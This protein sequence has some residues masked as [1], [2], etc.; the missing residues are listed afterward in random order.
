M[1]TQNLPHLPPYQTE[2]VRG[3]TREVRDL[4]RDVADLLEP[5][6][7]SF[8]PTADRATAC[9]ILVNHLSMRR[10]K[11]C[12]LA[13]HRT[14][15]DKLEELVWNGSDVADLSGQ[16]VRDG[17]GPNGAGGGSGGM[18]VSA[19]RRR[20]TCGSTAT[21][22]PRTRA[23]GQTSTSRAAWSRRGTYSSTSGS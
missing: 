3:V 22:W 17:S 23:T 18:R 7:G 14:R 16:Q 10:N 12:L 9:H 13:Y 5:F 2:L 8:D 19:R 21:S 1:W 6:N 11:R 4:D 20:T 15:T